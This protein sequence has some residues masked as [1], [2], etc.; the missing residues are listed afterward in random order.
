MDPN[1]SPR[2]YYIGSDSVM[3]YDLTS[4]LARETCCI[5]NGPKGT[6]ELKSISDLDPQWQILLKFEQDFFKIHHPFPDASCIRGFTGIPEERRQVITVDKAT[7]KNEGRLPIYAIDLQPRSLKAL[8]LDSLL[9]NFPS[10]TDLDP[11]VLKTVGVP[12]VIVEELTQ[13]KKLEEQ[14]PSIPVIDLA[15]I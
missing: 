14:V 12:P 4:S 15:K 2:S 11:K 6:L 9:K 13:H 5:Y 3:L 8:A 10:L 7:K 1:W